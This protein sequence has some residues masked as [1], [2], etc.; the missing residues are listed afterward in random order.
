MQTNE[1]SQTEIVMSKD[2]MLKY[3]LGLCRHNMYMCMSVLGGEGAGLCA[4][5]SDSVEPEQAS[6]LVCLRQACLGFPELFMQTVCI[7][8][9]Q[10]FSTVHKSKFWSEDV[11]LCVFCL[12]L[13]LS[14][15]SSTSWTPRQGFSWVDVLRTQLER[16]WEAIQSPLEVPKAISDFH[17]TE[18]SFSH[19]VQWVY[20]TLPYFWEAPLRPT[21]CVKICWK[22][23]Y[24]KFSSEKNIDLHWTFLGGIR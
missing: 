9:F 24:S 8:L 3:A 5:R 23:A 6:W 16:G 14:A 7:W 4:L 13:C 18:K 21:L 10:I 1:I 19:L 12:K 2:K 11:T 15:P 22:S 20:P 17:A